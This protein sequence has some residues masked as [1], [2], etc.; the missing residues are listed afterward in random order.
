MIK[1]KEGVNLKS[2]T[3]NRFSNEFKQQIIELF[4]SDEE[5]LLWI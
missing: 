5:S 2:S 4:Q 3:G 1:Y